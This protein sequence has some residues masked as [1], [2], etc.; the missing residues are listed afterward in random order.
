MRFIK[1][2][3]ASAGMLIATTA[4]AM[5]ATLQDPAPVKVEVHTSETHTVWY[6]DPMWLAIGGVVVL[7]IIVLAVMASRNRDSGS[8]TTVVR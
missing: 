3:L 1:T 7:L 8:T 5:A 6:A 2:L 4:T